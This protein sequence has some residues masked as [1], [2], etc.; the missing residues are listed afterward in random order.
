MKAIV[1][2]ILP[3]LLLL[4]AATPVFAEVKTWKSTAGTSIEAEFVSKSATSITL[5]TAQ[6]KTAI[7]P[8]SALMPES[9]A[10]IPADAPAPPAATG[11]ALGSIT[12]PRTTLGVNRG[13]KP[14]GGLEPPTAEE[15]AAFKTDFTDTDGSRYAFSSG[16]GPQ[17]LTKKDAEKAARLGKIPFRVTCSLDKFKLVNGKMR[18]VTMEG[19]GYIVVLDEQGQVVAS[20]RENLAK[21][22]PS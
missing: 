11:T 10:Q 1:T 15:I 17:R 20:K 12:T 3:G 9:Q 16:F 6:G 2:H 13:P 18:S 22:C 7:V 21:L 4:V 8:I 19:N 14:A 5:R